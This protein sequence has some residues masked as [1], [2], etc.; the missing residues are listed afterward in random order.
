MPTLSPQQS[1]PAS[2]LRHPAS[3]R[4]L[5]QL[6]F[7]IVCWTAVVVVESSY[8]FLFDAV[9]GNILPAVHYFAWATFNWFALALLTPLIYSLGQRYPITGANWA[10][11]IFLPHAFACLGWLITQAVFRGIAGWLYTLTHELPASA[12]TLAFAWIEDR[13]MVAFL[14]YWA[15]V[16]MAG[17]AQ[18]REE[19]RRRELRQAQLEIGRAHV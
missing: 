2:F 11:H 15:I 7:A 14:A 10:R 8:V 3:R 13:S 12:A 19:A 17:L 18:L 1:V 16:L 4:Y 6:P 9:R 5:A